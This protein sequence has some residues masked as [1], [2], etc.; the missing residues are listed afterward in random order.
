MQSDGVL[1]AW[2]IAGFVIAATLV[3]AVFDWWPEITEWWERRRFRK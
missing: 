1:V 2:L 3:R